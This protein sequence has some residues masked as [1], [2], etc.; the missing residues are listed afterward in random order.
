MLGAIYKGSPRPDSS[1]SRPTFVIQ[2]SI[3]AIQ[4]RTPPKISWGLLFEIP[5]SASR[6][7]HVA[8]LRPARRIW[9]TFVE[10]Q[11]WLPREAHA[12]F[13]PQRTRIRRQTR[14]SDAGTTANKVSEGGASCGTPGWT[15]G[16]TKQC[17]RVSAGSIGPVWVKMAIVLQIGNFQQL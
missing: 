17:I 2:T 12:S 9:A 14:L 5:A 7:S 15:R 3:G 16:L 4:A 6:A 13:P 8:V 1:S 11:P 10:S